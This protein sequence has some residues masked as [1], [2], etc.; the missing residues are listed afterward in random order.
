MD[1]GLAVHPTL[2]SLITEVPPTTKP[3]DHMLDQILSTLQHEAGPVLK[4]KFGLDDN[5]VGGTVNA[6]KDSMAQVLG[7][8]DGFG[9]DDVLSLFSSGANTSGADGILAKL[10]PVL[11]GKLTGQVG[12]DAAKAG[13]VKDMLLPLVTNLLAK[14]VQG[15]GGKL[16]GLLQGLGGSGGLGGIA[17][18]AL[19]K[20]FG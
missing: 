19:G 9:M 7:G 5:Q 11:Q 1:N 16:S 12:L 10:G 18:G 6:A 20:L 3:P 4:S 13:D 17:K 14:H 15:D 8:G 2:L